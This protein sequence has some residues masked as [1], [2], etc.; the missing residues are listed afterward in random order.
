MENISKEKEKFNSIAKTIMSRINKVGETM[1]TDYRFYCYSNKNKMVMW[2]KKNHIGQ[3]NR[4]ED[5]EV[6]LYIHC[7]L[8][9]TKILKIH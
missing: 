6:Y 2:Q 9:L 3:W 5:S 4:I 7:H 1:I 8:S